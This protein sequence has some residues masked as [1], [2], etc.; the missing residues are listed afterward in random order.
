MCIVEEEKKEKE[1]RRCYHCGKEFTNWFIFL[2]KTSD[3]TIPP[4]VPTF[5]LCFDCSVKFWQVCEPYYEH[6]W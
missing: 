5:I 4:Y 6:N 3:P 2:I 1:V